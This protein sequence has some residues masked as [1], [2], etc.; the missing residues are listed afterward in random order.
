MTI[1]DALAAKLGRKPTHAEIKT[2]VRRIIGEAFDATAAAGKL[3]H[4]K[5][6]VRR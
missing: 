5:K 2:E 4:Q 6:R 3:A 1:Y